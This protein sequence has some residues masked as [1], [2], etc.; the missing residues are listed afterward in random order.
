[1][2][3]EKVHNS[4]LHDYRACQVLPVRYDCLRHAQQI[5]KYDL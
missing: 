2:G 5:P 1:V 4:M 3:G